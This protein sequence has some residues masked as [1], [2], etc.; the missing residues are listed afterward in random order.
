MSDGEAA[1]KSGRRALPITLVV[2]ASIVL[3][4]GSFAVWAKRQLL[5]TDTWVETSTELLED[6]H[7]QGALSGFLVDALFTNV[8]V[9]AELQAALP[10]RAQPLAGP[11]AGGLR[12]LADRVALEALS[13][14]RVQE[15]WENANRTAHETFLD[16]VDN[17]TD[18]DVTLDLGTTLDELGSRLGL[19]VAS[20]LPPDA[21]QLEIMKADQL[22]AAQTVVRILRTLAWVL[23]AVALILYALAL[24]LAG[25][26]RR[27]TL[28]AVGFSFIVVGALIAIV[29]RIAGDA[30]VVSLSEVA[31]ADDAVLA[32]W[33]IG[34]SQLTDIASA[35]ILYGIFFVIAAWLAG[36]TSIATSLR[37]AVAPWFRQPRFA[38]GGL[39]ALLILIFWWD[40][41][42]GTH[43]LVPSLLLIVL[44]ILGT[45]MLRRQVIRE[46]PDRVTTGSSEGIAQG[47][48]ARMREARERR[49]ATA[50]APAPVA[51]VDP[52][53][54]E[55]ERLAGLR[56]SGAL[57]DE[58]FA[59][60][61][62]RILGS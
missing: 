54:A 36:P 7:I 12:Q 62:K 43:R 4:I 46:F 37:S 29:H 18:E 40:P 24:Y 58:E 48:A 19:D 55:L 6:E 25:D 35:L 28:R 13:R 9:E 21:G 3:L 44:L 49:L 17:D 10:P 22:A 38:Y 11:I 31:S 47:L 27:Q 2:S 23:A 8:D 14:P 59:A 42:P 33:T 26:R 5:E 16:V 30:V 15:L 60:E 51:E 56:D 39:A 45:E 61:K 52:R 53:I 1:T 50:G 32:T 34:T 57:T 41:T 20:K